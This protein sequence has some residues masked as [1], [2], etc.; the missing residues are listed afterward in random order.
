MIPKINGIYG[1]MIIEWDV[2][3]KN[4]ELLR[5]WGEER[6]KSAKAG[7]EVDAKNYFPFVVLER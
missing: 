6:Y 2:P 7:D 5:A 3:N 4:F 1:S